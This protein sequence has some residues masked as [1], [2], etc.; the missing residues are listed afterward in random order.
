MNR[1]LKDKNKILPTKPKNHSFFIFF[2]FFELFGSFEV[3]NYP[4]KATSDSGKII[5]FIIFVAKDEF[6]RA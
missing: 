2:L 4:K 1:F 5:E 3:T 6:P